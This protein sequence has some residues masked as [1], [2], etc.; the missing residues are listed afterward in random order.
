MQ[1]LHQFS[2]DLH[3]ESRWFHLRGGRTRRIEQNDEIGVARIVQ[4]GGA[5]LAERKDN[6]TAIA[7]EHR[8][9][10]QGDFAARPGLAKD[11]VE[12]RCDELIGARG[13]RGHDRFGRPDAAK[14]SQSDEKCDL[15]LRAPQHTHQFGFRRRCFRGCDGVEADGKTCLRCRVEKSKQPAGIRR[16]QLP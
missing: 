1:Y 4:F 10:R 13:E 6:D 12:R 16:N 9:F 15:L 14:V 5:V 8:C 2:R 11:E 7:I 3:E